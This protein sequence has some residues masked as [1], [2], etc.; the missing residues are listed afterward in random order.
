MRIAFDQQFPMQAA[1]SSVTPPVVIPVDRGPSSSGASGWLF[2]VGA[3]NVMLL[4]ILPLDSVQAGS[5][6]GYVLRLMETEGL[7]K[8]FK[9]YAF[10]QPSKARLRDFIGQ[11]ICPLGIDP[12]GGVLL[13]MAAYEA[14]EVELLW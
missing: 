12:D 5:A 10:R 4:K 9:L 8:A 11:T 13:E 1:I 3:K 6:A 7:A 2:H 14:C